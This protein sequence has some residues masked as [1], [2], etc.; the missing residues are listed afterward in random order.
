VHT[1]ADV[2]NQ[3]PFTDGYRNV[4]LTALPL[5]T[6]RTARQKCNENNRMPRWS[7]EW[8][9]RRSESSGCICHHRIWNC[10]IGDPASLPSGVVDDAQF[11]EKEWGNSAQGEV[12]GSGNPAQPELD[13]ERVSERWVEKIWVLHP[14]ILRIALLLNTLA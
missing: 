3:K 2:K 13:R 11:P 8:A 10:T 4:T 12:G 1:H 5:C 7:S 9:T 14:D 6:L